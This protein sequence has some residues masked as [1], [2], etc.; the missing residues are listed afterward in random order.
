[1]SDLKTILAQLVTIVF[2][3]KVWY[4]SRWITFL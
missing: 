2:N 3:S 1:M 4:F